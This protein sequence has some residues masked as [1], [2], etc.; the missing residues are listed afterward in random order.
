MQGVPKGAPSP[1]GSSAANPRTEHPA[2]QA[3]E[4]DGDSARRISR[5]GA[6]L[7]PGEPP[8]PCTTRSSHKCATL[9]RSSAIVV[10]VDG[11]TLDQHPVTCVNTILVRVPSASQLPLPALLTQPAR[12]C[13]YRFCLVLS[14]AFG[15]VR[16]RAFKR[17]WL[18]SVSCQKASGL[19]AP[20]A[21][22]SNRFNYSSPLHSLDHVSWKL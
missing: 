21:S 7:D 4:P 12:C 18:S 20:L 1:K 13:H 5:L 3:S 11:L 6:R 22:N 15:L 9:A 2:L 16:A 19:H 10:G 14:S 8:E 17:P